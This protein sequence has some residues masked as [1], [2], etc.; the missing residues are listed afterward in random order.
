MLM[1]S[2][3]VGHRK[4]W[5]GLRGWIVADHRRRIGLVFALLLRAF[6]AKGSSNFKKPFVSYQ[7][8][9]AFD[10][11]SR[12][13]SKILLRPGKH[14]SFLIPSRESQRTDMAS[15][16]TIKDNNT[17]TATTRKKGLQVNQSIQERESEAMVH[18]GKLWQRPTGTR[19]NCN[20]QRSMDIYRC[21]NMQVSNSKAFASGVPHE[22]P[23]YSSQESGSE[24]VGTE[25]TRGNTVRQTHPRPMRRGKAGHADDFVSQDC[26]GQAHGP[27]ISIN[28]RSSSRHGTDDCTYRLARIIR[29]RRCSIAFESRHCSSWST[30]RYGR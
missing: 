5:V 29:R 14:V 23:A 17:S 1:S 8:P 3:I 7:E 9:D 15:A 24:E 26:G 13:A 21:R 12:E 30:P 22:R 4:S 6:N 18:D 10:L 2:I 16:M 28:Y 11:G 27:L 20:T 25:S 19:Y